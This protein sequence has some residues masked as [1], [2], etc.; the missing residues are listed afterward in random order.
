MEPLTARATNPRTMSRYALSSA[1]LFA[2]PSSVSSL[3]SQKESEN[4]GTQVTIICITCNQ[5]KYIRDTLDGFLRQRTTFRFKV[6]VGEDHGTDSTSSIVLEYAQNHPDV[7]CPF[8]R[9][10]NLGAQRNL[11]DLCQRANSPYLALCEGDDFWTDEFKLQKQFEFME[12]HPECNVCFTRTEIDA[13]ADWYR[14]KEYLRRRDGKIYIPDSFPKF[15]VASEFHAA[16]L[17]MRGMMPHT[18]S[19]F[20]RWC[21]DIPFPDWYFQGIMGDVPLLLLQAGSSLV[22]YIP[23]TTSVYRINPG[24]VYSSQNHVDL[25]RK[26]RRDYI[27]FLSGFLEFAGKYFPGYPLEKIQ[28]RLLDEASEYFRILSADHDLSQMKEFLE[29]NPGAFLFMIEKYSSA[30]FE[31]R[32]LEKALHFN[33][34]HSL[35]ILVNRA[36]WVKRRLF[37]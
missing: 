31:S 23:D 26:T 32:N 27:R 3:T 10:R 12:N 36:Y 13:P 34:L 24:G 15:H 19:L 18:S 14:R 25:I 8:I 37:G 29:E 20:Y 22:G 1:A 5:E 28:K 33:V 11:I 4:D 9:E 6:F 35:S 7:V 21:Y 2:P 17:V 30:Y 16:D